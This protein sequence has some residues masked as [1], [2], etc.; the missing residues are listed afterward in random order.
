VPE[1][2]SAFPNVNDRAAI[3]QTISGITRGAYVI[4]GVGALALA[5]LIY[6]MFAVLS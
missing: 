1:P 6:G 2:A 3:K 4:L 5:G